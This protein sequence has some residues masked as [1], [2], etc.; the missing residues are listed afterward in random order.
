[1]SRRPSIVFALAV[2]LGLL[3]AGHAQGDDLGPGSAPN[4]VADNWSLVPTL[5]TEIPVLANDSDP[6]GDGLRVA[7]HTDPAYGSVNC[8]ETACTYVPPVRPLPGDDSDTVLAPEKPDSFTY[9]LAD[10][11]DRP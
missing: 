1:M 9:T 5:Q 3:A 11:T 6:D 4:A 10:S 2:S 7:S 8:A